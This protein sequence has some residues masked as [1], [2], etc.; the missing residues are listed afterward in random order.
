MYLCL[1]LYLYLYI[2]GIPNPVIGLA[3][4]EMEVQKRDL[5]CL[6]ISLLFF[7]LR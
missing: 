1:Y 5:V 7:V 3:S 4:P 2:S 6:P